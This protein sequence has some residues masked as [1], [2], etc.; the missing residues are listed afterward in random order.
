MAISARL[1]VLALPHFRTPLVDRR[2]V[3]G[4]VVVLHCDVDGQPSPQIRW[5]KN[6]TV[7]SDKP[8]L[9]LDRTHVGDAGN[10]TCVASNEAGT[11]TQSMMLT[12]NEGQRARLPPASRY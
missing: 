7:A 3:V 4:D 12:V 5:L 9:V 6:G 8:R 11:V 1:R 2:A 10:Y